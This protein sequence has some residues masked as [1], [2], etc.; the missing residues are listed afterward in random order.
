VFVGQEEH[1][2]STSKIND[3]FL[4]LITNVNSIW[5][6]GVLG[7]RLTEPRPTKNITYCSAEM[8]EQTFFTCQLS[9]R[10]FGIV[11]A[12]INEFIDIGGVKFWANTLAAICEYLECASLHWVVHQ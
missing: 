11:L 1:Q 12:H 9:A 5:G 6:F 2:N 3:K 8:P 7:A 10:V 4:L